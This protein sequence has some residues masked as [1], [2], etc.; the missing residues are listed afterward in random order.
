ML[1]CMGE[2][3]D[4]VAPTNVYTAIQAGGKYDN[5]VIYAKYTIDA[6]TLGYQTNSVEADTANADYDFRGIGI[7]YAVSEDI[8]VSYNMT[9]VD[10]E[11]ATAEDQA[12]TGISASYTNGSVTVSASM[13]DVD[14]VKGTAT[15]DNKAYEINF[16]F[17]F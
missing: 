12:A 9:D 7:S 16:G 4:G 17:A 6:F 2:N 13:H 15:V 10:Y 3:E 5:S 8:S 1:V 14:N 11:L